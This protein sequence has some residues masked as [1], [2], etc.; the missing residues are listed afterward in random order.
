[1]TAAPPRH[2]IHVKLATDEEV[3]V[4]CWLDATGKVV[5]PPKLAFAATWLYDCDAKAVLKNKT[6]RNFLVPLGVKEVDRSWLIDRG[7]VR[8]RPVVPQPVLCSR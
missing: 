7:F 4:A 8:G 3:I 2:Q 5:I 1:M 6:G